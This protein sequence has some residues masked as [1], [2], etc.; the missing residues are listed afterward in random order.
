MFSFCL[1]PFLKA[2]DCDFD[3]YPKKGGHYLFSTYYEKDH[4]TPRNDDCDRKIGA[5][6]Y[7]RRS[8]DKGH[9]VS[10]ELNY[11]ND[12]KFTPHI[13]T[14]LSHS[15]KK[16]EQ[17]GF[18]KE[19]N[20]KG[21]LIRFFEF[22][23]DKTGRRCERETEYLPTGT[24]R[25]IREYAFIRLSEIDSIHLNE[26]PPHTVDDFGYTSLQVPYGVHRWY[27]DQGQLV[28]EEH[29]DQLTFYRQD[30][31]HLLHGKFTEFHDHGKLKTQGQ[32]KEGNP[33]GMWKRYH[34][35]G[36]L[37][38]EGLY[39]NNIQDSLWRQWDDRGNLSKESLYDQRAENPFAP[40]RERIQRRRLVSE[41]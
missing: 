36:M 31:E 35:N 13:R 33:D 24:L 39:R 16:N 23:T 37:Y 10:E 5:Q 18:C 22:Y 27:N 34:Y 25:F 20:E 11:Y 7:A 15:T 4:Q 1:F 26:H 19:Y 12:G 17:L 9:I 40:V 3:Y 29:Y 2:Q 38:Q 8:F 14:Q 32:F 41:R 6:F 30:A 21:S 28:R